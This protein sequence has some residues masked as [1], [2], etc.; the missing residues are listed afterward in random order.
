MTRRYR[1][2]LP[3]GVLALIVAAAP[4]LAPYDPTQQFDLI[5]LRSQAPSL[6]HPFGTDAYARDVLSRV[7]FGGQVSLVV[8]I[9]SV[10]LGLG[11][12]TLY[13][14]CSAFAPAG[15]SQVLRRA[16]DVVL[17][18]PRVLILLSVL[19]IAGQM[20]V[21]GLV[22]LVGLTGWFTTGRQVTE[23]FDALRIQEFAIA[24]R[25]TGIRTAR[26]VRVHLVPHLVPLLIVNGTFAVANTIGIEAGLSFLGLGVQPP[27]A[28]WGTILNEGRGT[29]GGEWWLTLFPGL[30]TV[31]AVLAC[32]HAGDV[33]RER[34]A[35]AHVAEP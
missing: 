9:A 10:L 27:A 26:I 13:G 5:A 30:A 33:L 6:A 7:L 3:L 2:L 19:A 16:L 4:L 12:G 35:P 32:N 1:A 29:V 11:V 14:A 24:A 25:A 18:V 22:L 17:A 15:I 31:F 34:F 28:S 20:S 8:S 21:V 23:E